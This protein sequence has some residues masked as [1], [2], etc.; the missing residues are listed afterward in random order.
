MV[1]PS[2]PKPTPPPMPGTPPPNMPPQSGG[3]GGNVFGDL[4]VIQPNPDRREQTNER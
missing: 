4:P 1:N 3:A 2:D